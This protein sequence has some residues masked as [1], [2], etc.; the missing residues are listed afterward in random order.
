[1]LISFFFVA[2]ATVTSDVLKSHCQNFS[3]I[4]FALLF[5]HPFRET[6]A[7]CS[8]GIH[9]S[10][11]LSQKTPETKPVASVLKYNIKLV[12]LVPKHSFTGSCCA[13]VKIVVTRG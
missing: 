3:L 11:E 9:V 1:M 6:L 8:R 2:A 12:P 10:R 13:G 4:P 5:R 7:V